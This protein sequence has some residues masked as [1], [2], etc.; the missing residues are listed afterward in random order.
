MPTCGSGPPWRVDVADGSVTA[1]AV[2]V[3]TDPRATRALV[4]ALPA[5]DDERVAWQ[6]RVAGGRNAP[7]F[8]VL[9][10]WLDGRVAPEREAFLGTSG[11]DLLDN[12]TVLERFEAG[13]ARWTAEHGGSVVELH[14]YAADPSRDPDLAGDGP[15]GI[16]V[17][18]LRSRL[19]AGLHDVYPETR[20]LVVRHEE[21]LVEDDCGLVGT[22]PWRDRL[23]V[24]TPY[25]GLVLAGDGLRVDWPIALMERAATTGVLA[26]NRLLEG[27]GV[28][29]EDVWTV[30]LQGLVHRLPGRGRRPS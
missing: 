16:D 20:D 1:D 24:Q 29:G 12:V 5:D 28:R 9:R 13:A 25:P 21:L 18:R 22:G 10:V 14:A 6:R 17:E 30:P 7:P 2:V 3:A 26:A 4:G 23:T 8:G 11:Y 19:L 15:H 27:W